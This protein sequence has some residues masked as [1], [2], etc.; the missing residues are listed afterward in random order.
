MLTKRTNILFNEELF[1]HLVALANKNSTSVGDLVR[2][3][4]VKVYWKPKQNQE[5]IKLF[6]EIIRLK[7]GLGRISTKEIKDTINYGRR[8]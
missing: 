1:N 6:K 8:Y 4:V 3:A 7:K 5:K 2:K